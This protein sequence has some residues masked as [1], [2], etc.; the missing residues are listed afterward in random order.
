MSRNDLIQVENVGKEGVKRK[1][2]FRSKKLLIDGNIAIR[3]MNDPTFFIGHHPLVPTRDRMTTDSV[4]S[5]LST[6]GPKV[7]LRADYS[8]DSLESNRPS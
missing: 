1:S 6:R 3:R 2:E 4:S 5:D 7:F 8:S